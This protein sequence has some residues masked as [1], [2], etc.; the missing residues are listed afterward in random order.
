MFF[1]DLAENTT[2]NGI[3]SRICFSSRPYPYIAIRKGILLT[4]ENESGHTDDLAQ[5]VKNHLTITNPSLLADLQSQ[6]L[7]KAAGIFMWIVLVAGILN[8]ESSGGALAIRTK[9]SEIPPKL[10]DLFRSIM[11]RD[12]DRPE[13]LLLSVLW[14]LCVMK[15]T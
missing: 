7:D 15:L 4:L 5:Y 6:I 14:I 2:D 8:K 9:L 11:K 13:W 12:Q 1:E 3:Q 10:S